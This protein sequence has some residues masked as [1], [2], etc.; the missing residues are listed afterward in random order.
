M[1]EVKLDLETSRVISKQM[2]IDPSG[3][4]Q[5]IRS[6]D[7]RAY[8]CGELRTMLGRHGMQVEAVWGGLDRSPYTADS[9][10]LALRARK[11]GGA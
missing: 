7:L 3:G 6:Y 8:T 1:E 10:R 11:D 4:T 9:R 5:V 2:L